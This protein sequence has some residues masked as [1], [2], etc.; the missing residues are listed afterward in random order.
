MSSKQSPLVTVAVSSYNCRDFIIE[1]L[2][3]VKSQSYSPIQLIIIDDCSND[4]SVDLIKHWVNANYPD[5]KFHVNERN[6]G[7]TS[8]FAKALELAEGKYFSFIGSDDVMCS[9]KIE[10]QVAVLEQ[11]DDSVAATFSDSFLMKEDGSKHFGLYI[12]RFRQLEYVPNGYIYDLLAGG[13]F[14]PAHAVLTKTDHIREAG[15]FDTSLSFEDWDL[16]LKLAKAKQFIYT[17]QPL[18][19]YRIRKKSLMHSGKLYA[20]GDLLKVLLKHIDNK[21]AKKRYY[22]LLTFTFFE[23]QR[24]F[25]MHIP[26]IYKYFKKTK[27]F[28][29]VK[30]RF[31]LMPATHLFYKIKT[32]LLNTQIK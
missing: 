3:S 21:N 25:K 23:N 7:V 5:A 19:Y 26:Y 11:T 29:L 30:L 13:N 4:D 1:T 24:A 14:I 22:E 6:L 20:S 16:W 27:L 10:A 12:Q 15:G 8:V 31:L 18:V 28:Y 2:E 9:S 32:I 17:D